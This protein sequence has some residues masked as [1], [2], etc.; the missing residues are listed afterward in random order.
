M[1]GF[2]F[3]EKYLYPIPALR[4]LIDCVSQPTLAGRSLILALPVQ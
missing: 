3:N 1:R 4:E 2:Q